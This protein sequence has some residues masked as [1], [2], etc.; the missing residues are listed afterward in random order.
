MGDVRTDTRRR[1]ESSSIPL[2]RSA[3]A[4]Y[5][6]SAALAL[7]AAAAAAL[8]LGF[9]SL[10][11]GPEVSKGNLR[12]TALVVLVVGV[13]L[14]VAGM[15]RARTGSLKAMVFWLAAA[16][17]LLYQA[18]L[19]CFS[20]PL[21]ALFLVYV[22]WLGSGIWTVMIVLVRLDLRAVAARLGP[23][24][25]ARGIA[26]VL[27]TLAALNAVVWLARAVP[28]VLSERPASVLDGTGLL[29]NPIWV[30]DLAF[31]IPACVL[32]GVGMWQR[33]PLGVVLTG[34]LLV[35]LVVEALSI[36]SDQWWGARA[37]AGMPAVA[38][39]TMVPAFLVLGALTAVPLVWYF[40]DLGSA[41]VT[42]GSAARS[43][44]LTV[45]P[46]GGA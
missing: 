46:P 26:L 6:L 36:A 24:S 22:A 25:P 20:T 19:F 37:D 13:P 12:G 35:Q 17:Y 5:V 44:A 34:S 41:A 27:I 45:S 15:I 23:R 39:M 16:G 28:A 3:R 4:A 30:Q 40:R 29:T 7:C 2:L 33:R 11:A 9:P 43:P 31:W 21:N 38:S 8:S 18:V 32:A 1:D 42:T 14:L 10:L